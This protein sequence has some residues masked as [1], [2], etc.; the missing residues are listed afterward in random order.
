M[1]TFIQHFV[2][3]HAQKVLIDG[4]FRYEETATALDFP[5]FIRNVYKHFEMQYPKFYKMDDLSK[6]AFVG[7]ELLNLKK[8]DVY[9]SEDKGIVLMNRSSSLYTDALH[10][11]SIADKNNYFPSPAVFVYTLPNIAIGELC[12]RHQ[13]SGENYFFVQEHFNPAMLTN[14]V[15]LLFRQKHIQQC[16]CGWVE[17]N[18]DNYELF[19]YSV[20]QNSENAVKIV[21]KS[22]IFASLNLEVDHILNDTDN[23][24]KLYKL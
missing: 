24:K 19:L 4:V 21:D 20:E 5:A 17:L 7:A 10:Q 18:A 9:K 23:I 3:I 22:P 12:I 8:S 11:A 6:L 2:H 13:I 15:S 16:I 14:Y 1:K